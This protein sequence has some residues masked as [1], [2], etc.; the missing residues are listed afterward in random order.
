MTYYYSKFRSLVCSYSSI[1]SKYTFIGTTQRLCPKLQYHYT[2]R[3]LNRPALWAARALESSCFLD[4]LTFARLRLCLESMSDHDVHNTHSLSIVVRHFIRLTLETMRRPSTQDGPG[5]LPLPV[6]ED[7]VT[8][9][10]NICARPGLGSDHLCTC[11]SAGPRT[12]ILP[13]T[14]GHSP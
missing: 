12:A 14:I 7:G 3:R 1:D 6:G 9:N 5:H 13:P 10:N 2:R 4:E 11:A 8:L